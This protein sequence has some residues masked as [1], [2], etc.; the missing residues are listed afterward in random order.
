MVKKANNIKEYEK[1]VNDFQKLKSNYERGE[2]TSLILAQKLL[3]LE[4]EML[5]EFFDMS[6][7]QDKKQPKRRKGKVN[8]DKTQETDLLQ[9]QEVK[10]SYHS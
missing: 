6:T 1:A 8:I 7:T 5:M 10:G 4:R 3:T 9:Q 2:N